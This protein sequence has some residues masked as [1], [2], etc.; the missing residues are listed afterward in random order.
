MCSIEDSC[1][2]EASCKAFEAQP[3]RNKFN[4]N[5]SVEFFQDVI[6]SDVG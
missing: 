2:E 3:T 5:V 6:G 1:E 4:E